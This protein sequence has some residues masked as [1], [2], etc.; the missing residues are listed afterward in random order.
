M[1][2]FLLLW[3]EAPLQAWGIDSKF[4]RRETISFPTKSGILGLMLCAMG[5]SGPQRELLA[6]FAPLQQTVISYVRTRP[7]DTQAKARLPQ[8]TLLRDFHMV[9][10]G[11]DKD[12]P[13]QLLH[14]PKKIDGGQAE[15]G[16][17]K[18]THRF[19]LQDARFAVIL[20]VPL[21]I[22]DECTEKLQ[23]PVHDIYLGRKNCVPTDFV[24]RGMFATI[25]E[26]EQCASG[27]A[28]K[29][30]LLEDFRVVDGIAQEGELLIINDV[31]VQFG[32]RKI[33][34]DRQVS[35]IKV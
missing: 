23:Y 16:G 17:T 20:E 5:N 21:D 33:Y 3:L 6:R 1:N 25:A 15:G 22:A 32:D 13:W 12:D 28:E 7:T 10:S 19:Y 31:P 35:V 4:Y 26:A 8:E 34:R 27:I 29:K 14:I 30:S 9:G 2:R 11:Y 18:L 24:Y